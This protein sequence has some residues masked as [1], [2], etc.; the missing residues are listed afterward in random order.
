MDFNSIS[1]DDLIFETE[2]LIKTERKIT[3]LILW[4]ISEIEERKIYAQ[5][6]FESMYSYLTRALGYSESAAYR[7]LQSARLLKKVP[8]ISSKLEAGSLNLTQLAEVQ[9]NIQLK[10]D[11]IGEVSSDSTLDLLAKIENKNK[12]ET[13]KTIA[14][15]LDLPIKDYEWVR[16]QK[17][18]SLR[19]EM[20][21]SA[22][23]FEEL[24]KAKSFLSHVCPDGSWAE[25]IFQLAQAY[26][27][28]KMGEAK[29]LRETSRPTPQPPAV[30]QGNTAAAKRGVMK[31]V[32]AVGVREPVP[33]KTR[34]DVF[35]KAGYRCEFVS[36][37]T[38]RRCSSKHLL[39]IDHIK[40]VALGGDN[41]ESNLRLFCRTHNLLAAQEAGLRFNFGGPKNSS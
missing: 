18:D 25:V 16:P 21:L 2:R 8:E 38:R 27:R 15:E 4:H 9:K 6:G 10:K 11:K 12:F 31:G 33:S 19:I 37:Q 14:V 7:R 17:D 29:S 3:H 20:T 41:S 35:R 30:A 24:E 36:P 28:K 34:R 40:P 39:E 22:E 23:Q 26:N 1:D 13:Q 5:L 32:P